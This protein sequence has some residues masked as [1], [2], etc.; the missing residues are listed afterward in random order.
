MKLE[1][2]R[3]FINTCLAH[4]IKQVSVD[5]VDLHALIAVA[6]AARHALIDVKHEFFGHQDQTCKACILDHA[7]QDLDEVGRE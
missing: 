1:E 7:L 2:K 5:V 4:N 6:E 3:S